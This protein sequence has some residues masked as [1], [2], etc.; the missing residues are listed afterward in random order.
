MIL[1]RN[2]FS[3]SQTMMIGMASISFSLMIVHILGREN[4]KVLN[5]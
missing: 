1:S 4:G 2:N 3:S 5:T